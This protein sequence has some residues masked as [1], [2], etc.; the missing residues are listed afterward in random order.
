MEGQKCGTEMVQILV[1]ANTYAA[2]SP[3]Q[4]SF[5]VQPRWW[6][7]TGTTLCSSA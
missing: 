4:H 5:L 6:Q 3:E 2:L 1:S 7:R